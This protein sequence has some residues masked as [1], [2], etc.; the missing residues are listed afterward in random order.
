[1]WGVY[2]REVID[3]EGNAPG[4]VNALGPVPVGLTGA[5]DLIFKL[6]PVCPS[7]STP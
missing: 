6:L 2:L 7:V 1:M 4:C 5:N 3:T